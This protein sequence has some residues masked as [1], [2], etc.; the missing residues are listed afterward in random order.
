MGN[1]ERYYLK[2]PLQKKIGEFSSDNEY[3]ID[4]DYWVRLLNVG[5]GFFQKETFCSFG[6]WDQSTSINL[7]NNQAAS[8]K[9]FLIKLYQTYPKYLNKNYILIGNI[10]CHLNQTF[11]K[12]IYRFIRIKS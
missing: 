9:K 7:K 10:M 11:R 8:M 1:P 2:H 5:D 3:T 6:I 4:I 12:L